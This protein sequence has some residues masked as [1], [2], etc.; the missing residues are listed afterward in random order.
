MK[1]K[2]ILSCIVAAFLVW[3]A[4]PAA[5]GEPKA[6]MAKLC[7]NCHQTEPGVMMG[8]LENISLRART[9]QMDF[10]THKEIVKFDDHTELKNVLSLEDI[11]N[12]TSKGFAVHY[13]EKDGENLAGSII[14]FD[15]LKAIESGEY[16]VDRLPLEQFNARRRDQKTVV[17]DVRPPMLYQASHIPG[18]KSL[19]APAFDKLKGTLP[20]DRSTPII[21]YD[22]GGCL[23]P[24]VA[25]TLKSMGYQSVS[26]FTDGFPG[27]AGS[28]FGMT[29]VDWLKQAIAGAVPHVLIDL[30][31]REEVRAGHIRGAVSI[32]VAELEGS[33]EKFPGQKNAPIIL[34]GPDRDKAARTVLSWGYR[35]VRL[36]PVS[37]DQWQADGNPVAAGEAAQTITYVPKLKPGTVS[38]AE[39]ERITSGNSTA[40]V[41]IDVRN[42]DETAGG[43]I[44]GS[45][46]IPADQ[47][48]RRVDEIP[49]GKD[50]ILFCPSGVRAEMAYNL[51][52]QKGVGSRYLDAFLTI[53]KDGSYELREK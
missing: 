30:R 45:M 21:L 41:L 18:A 28:N 37:Y 3:S 46:N 4:S 16:K 34:Y 9:I 27:W 35:D 36:L 24:T 13:T 22:V 40:A 49:A 51:L 5:A 8:F 42:P 32:A 10:L 43:T 38:I 17:Y 47:I 39:F 33:R 52:D 53:A 12:Y 1:K 19:P 26:I 11:R 48:G 50:V 23:S 31:N 44:R 20:Q 29:T 7:A 15:V 14:R 2:R 6:P 25:F